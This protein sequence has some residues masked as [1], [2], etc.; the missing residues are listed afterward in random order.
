MATAITET[1][2]SRGRRRWFRLRKPENLDLRS[3]LNLDDVKLPDRM[4]LPDGI[5]LPDRMKLPDGVELPEV[6]LP[7]SLKFAENIDFSRLGL[8]LP[9]R[10]DLPGGL[11]LRRRS[12][13]RLPAAVIAALAG[14]IG[15]AA[16]F[17]LDPKV[18][19]SRRAYARD[20]LA[21]AARHLGRRA[22]HVGRW[23]ASDVSGLGQ[24]IRN[25]GEPAEPLDEVDLAHKVE[26]ELFRDRKVDKGRLNINA[27]R[28][29]VFLRGT[30]K[31]LEEISDIEDRVRKIDGVRHVVNLLHLPGSTP[32]AP[33]SIDEEAAT[34]RS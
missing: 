30:A 22:G 18:G 31:T 11:E 9:S 33:D 28:D 21:G 13:L 6:K 12:G 34:S 1:D 8:K 19:H 10:V 14:L 20:R 5:K 24:R 23:L 32:A 26:T 3:R 16:V 15:A 25:V 7:D 4:K 17:L 2:I 27:E 29:V